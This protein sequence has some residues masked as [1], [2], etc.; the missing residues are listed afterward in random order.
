MAALR[1]LNLQTA[2]SISVGEDPAPCDR[3]SAAKG[4]ES[5]VG[6]HPL[7]LVGTPGAPPQT[8]RTSASSATISPPAS[9]MMSA[10]LDSGNAIRNAKA[11]SS[12]K[13]VDVEGQM[14]ESSN[15]SV[16]PAMPLGKTRIESLEDRIC[17][18]VSAAIQQVMLEATAQL[19]ATAAE[20]QR[21]HASCCRP[22][23]ISGDRVEDLRV[24]LQELVQELRSKLLK[25]EKLGAPLKEEHAGNDQEHAPNNGEH[26]AAT[27]SRWPRKASPQRDSL[28]KS[29]SWQSTSSGQQRATPI[30]AC[31]DEEVHW[32]VKHLSS[33]SKRRTSEELNPRVV[34]NAPAPAQ[35]P[36]SVPASA[37]APRRIGCS[38][39]DESQQQSMLH[40]R[41]SLAA[42]SGSP[43]SSLSKSCTSL[44]AATGRVSL[45]STTP[46]QSRFS[47]TPPLS[48][49]Q[50]LGGSLQPRTPQHMR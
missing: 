48:S 28:A 31:T 18:A 20:L 15:A 19:R 16:E 13:P 40:L 39:V 26:A 17:D 10:R 41:A 36:A 42:R 49:S 27:P 6:S 11:V 1:K 24:D 29:E 14:C 38:P 8:A 21:Q 50:R 23:D 34:V 2:A 47:A 45:S 12:S 3:M 43:A 33:L 37:C 4:S 9:A 5:A 32:L 30:D 35:A 46:S 25:C 22:G 7:V 44:A